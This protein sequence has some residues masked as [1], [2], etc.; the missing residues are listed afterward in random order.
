[1][2]VLRACIDC[3]RASPGSRCRTCTAV[4]KRVRN[5]NAETARAVVQSSPVCSDCGAT[6]DLTSD[7]VLPLARGG[8]N[9]GP[10]RVLCRTCNSRRGGA[11]ADNEGRGRQ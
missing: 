7:H 9:A 2:T 11:L 6:R 5:G 8:S 4:R 3:G 10:Q 1:V